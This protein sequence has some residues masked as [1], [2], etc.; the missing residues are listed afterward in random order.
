[1]HTVPFICLSATAAKATGC[2]GTIPNQHGWDGLEL[3]EAQIGT[4]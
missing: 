4:E 1:M 2:Q 3:Y